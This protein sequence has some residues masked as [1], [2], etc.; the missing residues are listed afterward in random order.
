MESDSFFWQLLKQLPETLFAL[1]GLP[2]ATAT[3]YRFEAVEVKKSYR[4][5]GLFIP[6]QRTLPLY[7]I[8]AQFRR[9]RRFY[10]NLFAK[11]YSYLEKHDSNQDW[12]AVVLFEN[13]RAE[14][15]RQLACE[16]LIASRHLR[17]IYL[18]EMEVADEATP[19]LK[20]LQL[21]SAPKRDAAELVT[22]LLSESQRE[23]DCERGRIIVELMEELL[24]R[25]FTEMDREEVRRMFQLHDLRESKVWQEANQEGQRIGREK[26]REEGQE[27]KTREFLKRLQAKGKTLKEIA[28]LLDLPLADVRRMARREK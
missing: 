6:T 21:V 13:R 16:V 11:V 10:A 18:D 5:D 26:G 14:P 8:E 3:A 25:R 22:R 17:R 23:S 12:Q 20:L 9:D 24:M 15:K 19:G 27:M 1:L 28:E 4:H 7:F 2:T